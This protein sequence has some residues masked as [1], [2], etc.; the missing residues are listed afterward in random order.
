MLLIKILTS[1]A[2][3][4]RFRRRPGGG[5]VANAC[6][7]GSLASALLA[8]LRERI[9]AVSSP[10]GNQAYFTPPGPRLYVNLFVVSCTG[11]RLPGLPFGQ[12]TGLAH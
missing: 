9:A 12:D 3:A 5:Q 6:A 2:M 1:S 8:R 11:S 4:S 7:Q 10:K